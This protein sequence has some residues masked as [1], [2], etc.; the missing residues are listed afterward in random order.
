MYGPDG[1]HGCSKLLDAPRVPNVSAT[2]SVSVAGRNQHE[3]VYYSAKTF[4]ICTVNHRIRPSA[5]GEVR[6]KETNA[7]MSSASLSMIPTSI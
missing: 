4:G 6:L 7:F 5:A 3:T 2:K 1:R